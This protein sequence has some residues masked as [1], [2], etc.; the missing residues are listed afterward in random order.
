MSDA[1]HVHRAEPFDTAKPHRWYP[2]DVRLPKT[3]DEATAALALIDAR[4]KGA[5]GARE[6]LAA[7]GADVA[8]LDAL[9]AKWAIK[10]GEV[11]Y[12]AE[13]LRAG[14]DS[15]AAELAC[16]RR[17]VEELEHIIAQPVTPDGCVSIA[18]AT[19]LNRQIVAVSEKNARLKEA[20]RQLNEGA[21]APATKDDSK[22]AIKRQA[23]DACAFSIEAIEEMVAAG[24]VL[25]P[26][27]RVCV[28]EHLS[29]LPQGYRVTWRSRV[30]PFKRAAA[31][32]Q[33][34]V[35]P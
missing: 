15:E 12:V 2:A 17:R 6:D 32:V 25:T 27:A 30:L 18:H 14:D 13:R 5:S 3:E 8:R 28:D 29:A 9:L 31:D 7:K 21:A 19:S 35:T 1:P 26:L 24:A 22:A 20:L 4:V 16:L 23:H 11:A 33:G 10:R 34:E